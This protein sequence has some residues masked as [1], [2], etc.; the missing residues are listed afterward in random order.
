[1]PRGEINLRDATD[2]QGKS[3]MRV[4]VAFEDVRALYRHIFASAIRDLRPT[5]TVRS[6]SLEGLEYELKHFDPHVVVCSLPNGTHP[7]GSGAWVQ[8]PTDDAKEGDDRL[9]E[10]C[11]G[12]E[13]WRTDG[14]PLAELLAVIDEAQARLHEGS[15]SES[16]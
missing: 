3:T 9:A 4:L 5:L 7:T 2:S 13:R 1:M 14:P 15:L 11:L 12:G 8:I 10:I 16:C 6:A